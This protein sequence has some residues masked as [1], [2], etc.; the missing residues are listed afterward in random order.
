M[1]KEY[2]QLV[3]FMPILENPKICMIRLGMAVS[4]SN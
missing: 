3:Y 4:L 2:F 1:V